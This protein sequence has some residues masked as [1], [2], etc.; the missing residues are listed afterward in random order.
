M[1]RWDDIPRDGRKALELDYITIIETHKRQS[2][3][4]AG[5]QA[6]RQATKQANYKE[7]PDSIPF[8]HLTCNQL[9]ITSVMSS[10]PL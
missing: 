8:L 10:I 9:I 6:G 5:R 1:A 4:Q 7:A 3:R 2:S